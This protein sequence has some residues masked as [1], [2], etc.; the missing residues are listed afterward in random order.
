MRT[1]TTLRDIGP[2]YQ[3]VNFHVDFSAR[4]IG[5]TPFDPTRVVAPD[6]AVDAGP[7]PV[8][9]PDPVP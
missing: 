8:A 4:S 3:Y 2:G 5:V 9:F 6:V 1:T 7:L